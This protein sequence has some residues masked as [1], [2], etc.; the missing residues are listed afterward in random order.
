MDES[1]KLGIVLSEL[2]DMLE[3]IEEQ[4]DAEC[5][6]FW[7][8]LSEEDKL[9]AFFSVCKRIYKGDVEDRRSYRGVLYDVFGFGSES[10]TIGMQCGYHHLHN[11]IS[12]GI[13]AKEIMK[14]HANS[15]REDYTKSGDET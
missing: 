8:D 11:L 4:Y 14:D 5:N 6:Q 3:Q 9:K 1:E 10:Y 12:E 7:D 2:S 13:D 15:M